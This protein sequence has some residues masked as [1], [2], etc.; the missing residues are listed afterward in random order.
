MWI[1]YLNSINL[2]DSFTPHCIARQGSFLVT[3]PY[4]VSSW[5]YLVTFRRDVSAWRF[6]VT[7]R[8]DVSAWRFC[9][10]FLHDV[11]AW[12]FGVTFQ[13]D[14]SAWRFGMTFWRDISSCDV[15]SPDFVVLLEILLHAKGG[16][17]FNSREKSEN[18]K[19]IFEEFDLFVHKAKNKWFSYLS[20]LAGRFLAGRF[21][22]NLSPD[23]PSDCIFW[24]LKITRK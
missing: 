20:F 22:A 9:V 10:T 13:H 17:C 3:F 6:C 21:L 19:I 24:S 5:C 18:R 8:R 11:S 1:I 2:V 16:H 14:V 12:R 15:S 4:Y 23:L 7:F